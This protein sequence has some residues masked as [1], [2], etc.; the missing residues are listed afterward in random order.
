MSYE[1]E[2]LHQCAFY[3]YVRCAEES[4]FVSLCNRCSV[5]GTL[6]AALFWFLF[7]CFS[8]VH[9]WNML[10]WSPSMVEIISLAYKFVLIFPQLKLIALEMIFDFCITSNTT[11]DSGR[12]YCCWESS[13]ASTNQMNVFLTWLDHF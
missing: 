4:F 3:W 10:S 6:T 2:P 12:L 5:T 9:A 13:N 8:L 7:S 1:M 11:Q